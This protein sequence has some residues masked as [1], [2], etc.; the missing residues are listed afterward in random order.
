MLTMRLLVSLGILA[1]T[2]PALS[3]QFFIVQDSATN[4]CTVAEQPPDLGSTVSN[5]LPTSPPYPTLSRSTPSQS[6][7]VS[8]VMVGDGAYGDRAAAEA[9]MRAIAACLGVRSSIGVPLDWR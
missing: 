7:P 1:L 3:A 9:D 8:T 6:T 2:T 5:P 4:R